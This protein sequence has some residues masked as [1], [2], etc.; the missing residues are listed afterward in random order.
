VTSDERGVL[1]ITSGIARLA[2]SCG[3]LWLLNVCEVLSILSV[4]DWSTLCLDRWDSDLV[5]LAL[6]ESVWAIVALKVMV[7]DIGKSAWALLSMDF[8]GVLK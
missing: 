7:P 4:T 5:R 1:F 8:E 6:K 2:P 3:D